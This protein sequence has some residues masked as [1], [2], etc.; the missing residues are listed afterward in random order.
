VVYPGGVEVN[1]WL[2]QIPTWGGSGAEDKPTCTFES[3]G[4]LYTERDAVSVCIESTRR[5]TTFV[6]PSFGG[7]GFGWVAL[8]AEPSNQFSQSIYYEIETDRPGFEYSDDGYY[9]TVSRTYSQYSWYEYA[10]MDNCPEIPGSHDAR[11]FRW[12]KHCL[13]IFLFYIFNPSPR[14]DML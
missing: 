10:T 9:R 12:I 2:L 4:T 14:I 7:Y 5:T 8:T 3:L 6:P 11:C 1:E 13:F